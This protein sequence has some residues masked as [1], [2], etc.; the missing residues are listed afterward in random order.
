MST[1]PV[2]L[3][4]GFLGSGKTTFLSEILS[5]PHFANTAVIVNEFGELGLDNL[6]VEC[7]SAEWSDDEM[8]EMTSGC[9]CCTIRG[10][11]RESLRRLQE[12]R[13]AGEIPAFERLVIETTGLADP[14]PVIHTLMAERHFT[15]VGVVTLVDCVNASRTLAGQPEAM[16]QIAMAD[17]LLVSKSDLAKDLA[18]RNDLSR[19]M[20]S[21][22]HLNP[23]AAIYDRN[24]SA[25]D[26][27]KLFGANRYDPAGKG[28][29]V[30]D[31]L[32]VEAYRAAE[33]QGHDHDHAHG[34]DHEH[35]VNRHGE[36]IQAFA[37]IFD[38]P[39]E[40]MAFTFAL[41]F[42]VANQGADL[43]RVKGIVAFKDAPGRPVVIHGVQHIYHDPRELTSWPD[44][45]RR[46][47]LVFIT[48]GISRATIEAF[49]S[50]WQELEEEPVRP[51]SAGFKA[52]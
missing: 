40:R 51:V 45:D 13:L 44:E 39:L 29:E 27:I 7:S 15:L 23:G 33:T 37:L 48:R 34:H 31:W 46:S 8:L 36:E 5:D 30:V 28:A 3:L 2:T 25:F 22:R 1:I 18:S 9:L 21:L 17:V 35:D 10:D 14:A 32:K 20:T 19:L 24:D 49:F 4:T 11:I 12:R 43:L 52:E 41:K 16:K 50:A 47:K 38:A 26:L 42:L 6:L